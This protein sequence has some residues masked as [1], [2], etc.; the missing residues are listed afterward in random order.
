MP[1]DDIENDKIEVGDFFEGCSFHPLV[2]AE[3]DYENDSLMGISLVDG[4]LQSCSV[5]SC[6]VRKLTPREALTWRFRGPQDIWVE[7]YGDPDSE[8]EPER[9]WWKHEGKDNFS[10]WDPEIHDFAKSSD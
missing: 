5:R 10:W 3:S 2:C 6:G 8:W 4:S 9:Q 1:N 7:G